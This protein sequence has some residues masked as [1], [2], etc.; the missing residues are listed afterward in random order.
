MNAIP[1]LLH[2][3]DTVPF[4]S[5]GLHSHSPY[6]GVM[7]DEHLD[8][9]DASESPDEVGSSRSVKKRRSKLRMVL[10][11]LLT[12]VLILLLAVGGFLLYLRYIIDNDIKHENLLPNSSVTRDPAAGGAQ[13]ILLLGSDSRDTSLRDGSRSDVIQ[14]VHISNDRKRIDVVHFPRDLYVEIPGHGKNKINAAYAYGGPQLLVQTLEK[15][16]NVHIDHVA[17][18]GFDG[19]KK[20]TDHMGGVDI[21]VN[22]AYDEGSFGKFDKGWNHM[23]GTQA[24]GFV[25]ERHQLKL[26]DIDRGKNQQAWLLAMFNKA[27]QR[28][29]LGNPATIIDLTKDISGNL[30]VDKGLTT[31]Y[32][33]GIAFSLRN[34]RE[35]NMSFYTAPYTGFGT[36][37]VVGAVDYVDDAK[38]KRLSHALR[39]DKMETVKDLSRTGMKQ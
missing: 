28:N 13:N 37:K 19:F 4:R 31:N 14:L 23:N 26:G 39:T 5:T 16:T 15:L 7:V 36:E 22:Q 32:M 24:L 1:R 18:I 6:A 20:A 38:M 11:V 21:Y 33:T 34:V 3:P 12:M 9:D 17:Q 27:K 35:S 2:L 8:V 10:Y 29:V 30:A 25:R